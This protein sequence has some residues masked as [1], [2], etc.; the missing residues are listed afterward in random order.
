MLQVE[1]TATVAARGPFA[2]KASAEGFYL[3]R[4]DAQPSLSLTTVRPK[5]DYLEVC[6]WQPSTRSS[7]QTHRTFVLQRTGGLPL[8]LRERLTSP[9]RMLASFFLLKNTDNR[10]HCLYNMAAPNQPPIA[11]LRL[12]E[13]VVESRK[14]HIWICDLTALLPQNLT[15]TNWP[16]LENTFATRLPS[17]IEVKLCTNKCSV[18]RVRRL[19][20]NIMRK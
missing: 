8:F 15:A 17:V 7:A 12:L 19:W 16:T 1:T 6:D 14:V 2:Q 20:D 4:L 3:Q 11:Q 13:R 18:F 9:S 10:D 5:R